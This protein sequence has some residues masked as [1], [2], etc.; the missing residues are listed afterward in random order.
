M[1]NKRV[2][3]QSST[4]DN[5]SDEKLRTLWCGSVSE[6]V[7]E[8]ILYE[9]F[10]NAGPLEKVS[11]PKDRDTG[12][13]KSY[14]F[15]VFQHAESVKYAFDLLNGTELFRQQI[16]LQQKETGLGTSSC[17][18]ILSL[19]IGCLGMGQNNHQGS[20]PMSG[21]SH[22]RSLPTPGHQQYQHHQMPQMFNQNPQ[23]PVWNQ[24]PP[25]PFSNYGQQSYGG[26][27]Q[28]QGMYGYGGGYGGA[29]A[30]NSPNGHLS[31]SYHGETEERRDR[32]RREERGDNGRYRDREQE[33]D[34]GYERDRD[35]GYGRD[36][37][38]SNSRDGDRDRDRSYERT[39]RSRRY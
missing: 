25:S 11:L 6:K 36:R 7:D 26:Q 1:E 13:Q 22:R 19:M 20:R 30:F 18:F 9:L 31:Q 3:S 23:V 32:G 16:R 28:G 12:R 27:G 21:G 17:N 34:R 14:A 4:D 38:Y 35:R 37:S 2:E 10:Q 15:I 24:Y 8:E 39:N 33:R 29:G 5:I